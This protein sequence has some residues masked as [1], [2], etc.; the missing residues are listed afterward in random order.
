MTFFSRKIKRS[1]FFEKIWEIFHNQRPKKICKIFKASSK[2][3]S[4]SETK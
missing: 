2:N 1:N 3:N 4:F